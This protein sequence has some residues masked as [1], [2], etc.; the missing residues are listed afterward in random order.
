[1]TQLGREASA[2]LTMDAPE[3][4]LILSADM[5]EGHNSAAR[6]LT[7]VMQELWSGCSVERLDTVELRGPLFAKAARW[8]YTFQIGSAPWTYQF[9]YDAICRWNG[10]ARPLKR[11]TAWFF[12]NR[13]RP[14]IEGKTFDLIV[15]TYPL[16]SG[17]LSWLRRS[18]QLDIPTVTYIPALHVHPY[19]VYPAIDRHF[20][21]YRKALEDAK[22]PEAV[23]TM[24]VGAPPIRRGFGE[25][26][27]SE[28][29]DRLSLPQDSFIVLVT[30]GAW[31]LGSVEQAVRALIEVGDPV[32]VVAISGRNRELHSRLTALARTS[33]HLVAVGFTDE[34]AAYMAASNVV[35][36]NGAGVTVLEALSTPRP[37]LAFQ[38][39]A[40]H[41]RAASAV[42]SSLDLALVCPEV[43]DLVAA[44]R[45]L[46]GDSELLHSM[47]R[48]GERFVAGKDLR[49]EVMAM[50]ELV[51][52][53]RR[54]AQLP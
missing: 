27:R 9:F 54:L 6:A 3:K 45:R 2:I 33:K 48:A 37:V 49:R 7:E 12:G 31:G 42:M 44:V 22:T 47:E 24:S 16:G 25:L 15:S 20:V 39:L 1:M 40:G 10:F 19:W 41:G 50:G 21:M 13:L 32:Q 38:P 4:V 14:A 29:R 8:L 34:M 43:P 53:R 52:S 26:S 35:V 17:A 5:G 11:M 46:L 28:A 51:A 18:G 30:G 23:P 36:T